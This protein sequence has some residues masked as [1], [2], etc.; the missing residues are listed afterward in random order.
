M[1]KCSISLSYS[2]NSHAHSSYFA[3]HN[4]EPQ[5]AGHVP[6]LQNVRNG[7]SYIL[8]N[9]CSTG[10][11]HHSALLELFAL[12]LSDVLN[13]Q[14]IFHIILGEVAGVL[15]PHSSPIDWKDELGQNL[16]PILLKWKESSVDEQRQFIKQRRV[17]KSEKCCGHV[18]CEGAIPIH[19]LTLAL[20]GSSLYCVCEWICH[21]I[22][23]VDSI[24]TSVL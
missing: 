23:C 24:C 14:R 15:L 18:K 21:A 19:H 6:I 11:D 8:S 1:H 20:H 22:W 12:R 10:A 17:S 2:I 5:D 3:Y 9:F 7:C 13:Q 16:P 4:A